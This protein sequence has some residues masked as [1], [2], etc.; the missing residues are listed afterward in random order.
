MAQRATLEPPKFSKGDLVAGEYE[1]VKKLGEGGAGSVYR[2]RWIK[3]P[4]REVALKLLENNGDLA[5]FIREAKLLRGVDHPHVIRLLGSGY[6]EQ[7]PFLILEFMDG[8]SVRD[9]IESR[10]GRLSLDEAC[11][12]II[13]AIRG[14]RAS[15]TVHRDLKPENLLVSKGAKGRGIALVVGDIEAGAVV[16]VADF[17]LAKQPEGVMT[18]LTNSGQVM[19]TPVYMSPEQCRNTKNV[20]TKSDIYSLGILLYE[21][22]VGRVPFDGSNA[23]DIMASH[24]NDEPKFPRMDARLKT[25]LERC[26][27]KSPGKRYGSLAALEKDLAAIAGLKGEIAGGGAARGFAFVVLAFGVLATIAW[28]LRDR[29]WGYIEPLLPK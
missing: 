22:V 3:K 16:K 15:K 23:Y 24:C 18:R 28:F 19:G 10:G 13:Q 7:R 14:L 8:G 4:D 21:M 11:W 25:V 17:G 12:V 5:R 20:G 26:L 6:H 2:C 1:V 9:L 29:W 27:A